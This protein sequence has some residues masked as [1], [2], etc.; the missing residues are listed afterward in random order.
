VV[1]GRECGRGQRIYLLLSVPFARGCVPGAIQYKGQYKGQF[2]L[3]WMNQYTVHPAFPLLH[4]IPLSPFTCHSVLGRGRAFFRLRPLSGIVCARVSKGETDKQ[5][6]ETKEKRTQP[7]ACS[8]CGTDKF[9]SD[10]MHTPHTHT[11]IPHTYIYTHLER[12]R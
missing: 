9:C 5:R 8:M 1:D 2:I 6:G 10:A 7:D 3:K 4:E 11:H 12:A